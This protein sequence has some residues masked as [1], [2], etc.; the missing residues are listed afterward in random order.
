V[1][2]FS[3]ATGRFVIVRRRRLAVLKLLVDVR[4]D[5]GRGV[6]APADRDQSGG[7]LRGRDALLE[8]LCRKSGT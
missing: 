6:G 2:W 7:N 5:L 3:A 1:P 8:K 4:N